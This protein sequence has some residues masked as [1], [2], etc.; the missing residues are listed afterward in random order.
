[1]IK[2]IGVFN[3]V[4]ETTIPVENFILLDNKIFNKK[5]IVL[6]NSEI[7]VIRCLQKKGEFDDI[8]I[9]SLISIGNKT[10]NPNY[11]VKVLELVNGFKPDI[12]HV[13]H[14]LSAISVL[15]L[16]N[17]F[18]N[19]K[20]KIVLTMHNDF[21]YYKILQKASFKFSLKLADHVI[22]N[23]KNTLLKVRK[24]IKNDQY[25]VIYNGVNKDQIICKNRVVNRKICIGTVSRLIPQ[26]DHSTLIKAMKIVVDHLG[27]NAPTLYIVGDGYL[28]KNIENEVKELQIHDNVILTGEIDRDEVY[29][30]LHSFDIFVVS[31]IF[32]GFCNAMVEAMMSG[33]AIITSDVDPLPEVIGGSN[34][35]IIFSVGDHK[36]LSLEIL[37]LCKDVNVRTNYANNAKE[38][39]INNYSMN[40]C[41]SEHT[42]L[43]KKLIDDC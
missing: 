33:C 37:R 42:I 14:T 35:G 25:S 15:L 5:I 11:Y 2:I 22:A 29:S 38:Y 21:R 17:F 3:S 20:T 19:K 12:I 28:R 34:N 31:S 40:R 18:V 8:Q 39:S 10:I 4:S 13:H 24:F 36:N 9:S 26:K 30:R 27:E 43:Y 16:K 6:N 7:E 23:S 41:V 1:M 32:E